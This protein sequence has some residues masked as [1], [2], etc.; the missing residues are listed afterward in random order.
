MYNIDLGVGKLWAAWIGGLNAEA[1][2]PGIGS[3]F[4]QTFDVRLKD[5][6]LGPV[7]GS[8][9]LVLIGNYEK[10]GTFTQ[11]Y[12]A[13]GDIVDLTNPLHTDSAWGIGG[14]RHL[15]SP[16]WSRRRQ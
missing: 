15:Y 8:L 13:S 5:I 10:G 3:Y 11:E 7:P 12:D 9:A 6:Q 1:I 16:L 14:R 2:S 4:K